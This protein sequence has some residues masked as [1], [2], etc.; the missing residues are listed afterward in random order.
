MPDIHGRTRDVWDRTYNSLDP[1]LVTIGAEPGL[2]VVPCVILGNGHGAGHFLD[3]GTSPCPIPNAELNVGM[4]HSVALGPTLNSGV[5]PSPVLKI[6]WMEGGALSQP[7][8]LLCAWAWKSP[9]PSP[10]PGPGLE[11]RAL[12][13]LILGTGQGGCVPDLG[14]AVGP[15]LMLSGALGWGPGFSPM[16]WFETTH[17]AVPAQGFRGASCKLYQLLGI[18][19]LTDGDLV[20]K[21]CSCWRITKMATFPLAPSRK[22][23]TRVVFKNRTGFCQYMGPVQ[24]NQAFLPQALSVKEQL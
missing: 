20:W 8:E 10:V 12:P 3:S 17:V 18:P 23:C 14:A 11:P 13:C 22:T 19:E 24:G 1:S 5:V 2:R 4:G 9:E 6:G 7:S 16:S 15:S 21:G